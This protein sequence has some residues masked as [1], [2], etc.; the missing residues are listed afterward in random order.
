MGQRTSRMTRGR[1]PMGIRNMLKRHSTWPQRVFLVVFAG[2]VAVTSLVN[3]EGPTL[4][5]AQTMKE[6]RPVKVYEIPT[7]LDELNTAVAN[8]IKGCTECRDVESPITLDDLFGRSTTRVQTTD[9]YLAP[10]LANLSTTLSERIE[11]AH[12]AK[13][14]PIDRLKGKRNEHR[15]CNR[16]LLKFRINIA[17][18]IIHELLK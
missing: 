11:S 1:S 5:P 9:C 13:G 4:A 7:D 14:W 2:A 10:D 16:K 6:L 8:L 15:H 12:N 18:Q 17:A 3:A